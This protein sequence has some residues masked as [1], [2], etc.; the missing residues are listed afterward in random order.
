MSNFDTPI[1]FRSKMRRGKLDRISTEKDEFMQTKERI[2]RLQLRME[3]TGIDMVAVGPTSN[4]SYLLGFAPHADERLCTL[5]ISVHDISMIVPSLNFEETA[6]HTSIH[7]IPWKDSD[8]PQRTLQEVRAKYGIPRTLAVD[9]AMRAD[10]VIHL[11][12]ELTPERLIP[13]D[14]LISTLRM[15]KSK[16]EIEMLAHAA[17]QADRAMQAA[18]D[19]CNPGITEKDVAWITES[20]FRQD[21]AEEVCFTLIASGPNGAFPHH[22]SSHRQMQ[23]G[24]AIIIDIGASLNGYKSDITRMV[25]LGEPNPEFLQVYDAVHKANQNAMSSVKPGIAAEKIDYAARSSLEDAGYGEVFVHR[26]GHGIGLDVHEPPWIMSGNKTILEEGMT[27]S[28][29]PGAYLVGKFGVRIE[30]IVVVTDTG[31]RNFTGFDHSLVIKD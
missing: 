3:E 9:G 22:H 8:G 19:A 18:I 21:G 1:S 15:I 23:K 27:F 10:S 13:V 7:L 26:T 14:E 28:I 30:D 4:M 25:H 24:D 5:L 2:A 16:N 17:A 29:E 31:V 11:K 12:N 6:A 20:A